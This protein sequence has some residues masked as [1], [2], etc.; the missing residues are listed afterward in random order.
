MYDFLHYSKFTLTQTGWPCIGRDN[1][2][3][4]LFYLREIPKPQTLAFRL[5][6]YIDLS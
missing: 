1:F 2:P 4:L 3:G 6:R 5:I